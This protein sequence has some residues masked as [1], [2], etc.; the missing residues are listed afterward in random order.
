MSSPVTE[1]MTQVPHSVGHDMNLETAKDMMLK[2]SC[3]HLPVLDGGHLVGVLSDTDIRKA[4]KY[5][6]SENVKVEDIMTDEPIVVEPNMDVFQVAMIMHQKKIGSVIVSATDDSPWA[7]SQPQTPF[8]ISRKKENTNDQ[9]RTR[10]HLKNQSRCY[11]SWC[12]AKR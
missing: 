5:Q 1:F 2:Y 9:I 10:R 11:R 4:E 6:K 7:S 3:H 12:C 8:T